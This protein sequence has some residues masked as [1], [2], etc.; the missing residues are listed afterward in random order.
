[1]ARQ[2]A[3]GLAGVGLY[4]GA[5]PLFVFVAYSSSTG[6]YLLLAAHTTA[7]VPAVYQR[8]FPPLFFSSTGGGVY[9]SIDLHKSVIYSVQQ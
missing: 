9:A 1:M 4:S 5:L 3:R 6:R 2:V 8:C 7:A